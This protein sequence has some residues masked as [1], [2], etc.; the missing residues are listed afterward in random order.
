M[1]LCFRFHLHQFQRGKQVPEMMHSCWTMCFCQAHVF[2]APAQTTTSNYTQAHSHA[3]VQETDNIGIEPVVIGSRLI[4]PSDGQNDCWEL[5]AE[6]EP[7]KSADALCL[8]AF[9]WLNGSTKLTKP[10]QK[11]TNNKPYGEGL[12]SPYPLPLPNARS[13]ASDSTGV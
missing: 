4:T 3:I 6:A 5:A 12:P 11:P 7:F 13:A 10:E 2:V 9:R 1:S 8:M